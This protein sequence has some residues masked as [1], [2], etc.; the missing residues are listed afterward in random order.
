MGLTHPHRKVP[1]HLVALT[2]VPSPSP[3]CLQ[4]PHH[5]L[6]PSHVLGSADRR[7][8]RR[9]AGP[10]LLLALLDR[11]PHRRARHALLCAVSGTGCGGR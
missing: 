9:G 4:L 10:A 6:P 3:E 8:L 11:L 1:L 2:P 7:L 5:E